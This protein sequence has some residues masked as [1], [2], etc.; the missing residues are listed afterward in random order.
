MQI[1]TEKK[2]SVKSMAEEMS[3]QDVFLTAMKVDRL[4]IP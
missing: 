1:H 4:D 3:V 2:I